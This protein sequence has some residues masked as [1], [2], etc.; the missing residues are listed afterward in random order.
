MYGKEL[1]TNINVQSGGS[2]VQSSTPP[3]II[4]NLKSEISKIIK[5]PTENDGFV[6]SIL[7][8]FIYNKLARVGFMALFFMF[9]YNVILY[10][11]NFFDV[12]E[13][14]SYTYT[15]WISIIVILYTFLPIRLSYLPK[16]NGSMTTQT[17]ILLLVTL[18]TFVYSIFLSIYSSFG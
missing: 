10:V 7:N 3:K 15:L 4:P 12:D 16:S 13:I 5:P 8:T 9:F 18:M 2:N 14:Y 1:E 17:M 6:N 11:F